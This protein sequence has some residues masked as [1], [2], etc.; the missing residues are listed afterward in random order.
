MKIKNLFL[1][2]SP[3]K[4]IT[5]I[6]KKTKKLTNNHLFKFQIYKENRRNHFWIVTI[7]SARTRKKLRH[8][9]KN[10]YKQNNIKSTTFQ[11]W[12]RTVRSPCKIYKSNYFRP[13]PKIFTKIETPIPK[14]KQTTSTTPTTKDQSVSLFNFAKITFKLIL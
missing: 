9:I 1:Q 14:Y 13:F 12:S 4:V 8:I 3:F 11:N 10:L 7:K 5:H 2:H 6:I